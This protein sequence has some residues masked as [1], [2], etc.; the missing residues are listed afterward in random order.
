MF[1]AISDKIKE[2]FASI[3]ENPFYENV[4]AYYEALSER[5]KIIAKIVS[6]SVLFIIIINV[7]FSVLSNLSIKENEL[8]KLT[9]I[10]QNVDKL[11]NLIK[12]N[13]QKFNKEKS[14]SLSK[15]FISLL[16]VVEKQQ[17][18]SS[19]KPDSRIDLKE[20]PRREVDDGKQYENTADVKYSKITIRQLVKLLSGIEK[21]GISVKVNSLKIIR[22]Y[23]D[24][25]YLDVDF[26]VTARTPKWIGL[27]IS[28]FFYIKPK[29]A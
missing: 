21:S 13:K 20:N 15:R 3:K 18:I 14:D 6:A 1:N 10:N 9:M 24:I 12:L 5:D 17:V 4:L 27:K 8:T 28:L 16:D 22:K 25:R 11:N 26:S 23:D 2:I 29:L 7:L 19:I